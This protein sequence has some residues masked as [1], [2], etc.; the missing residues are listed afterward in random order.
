M[1]WGGTTLKPSA[2]PA[3]EVKAPV[4]FNSTGGAPA[5]APSGPSVAAQ[6]VKNARSNSRGRTPSVPRPVGTKQRTAVPPYNPLNSPYANQGQFNAA[7][8][9]TAK[10]EYQPELDSLNTEQGS[11]EGAHA[12][13]QANNVAL[14]EQYSK[15][16]QEAYGQAQ[17]SMA[18]IA[19]RQNSSTAAGQQTLQAALS[20]TGVAGLSGVSNPNAFMSEATGLG[21]EGSQTLAGEQS[22]ITGEMAKDMAG[23]PGAGLA[24]ATVTENAKEAGAL[25]KISGE[26][27]KVLSNIPNV[28]SKVRGELSKEE[29]ERQ[30]NNLQQQIAS[31]KL[32]LE[33]TTQQQSVGIEKEKIASSNTQHHEDAIQKNQELAVSSGFEAEKLKLER[34]KINASI[35]NAKTAEQKAAAELSGKR[36]DHGLELMA[37][38]LKENPKTEY[39]PGSLPAGTAPEP[40]KVEYR[41][42]AQHLYDMLTKQGNLT[43]PEAFR[44]MQSSGNGY[45]EQFARTHEHI[46][47]EANKVHQVA[48][49]IK[50]HPL[51]P[52]QQGK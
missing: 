4:T 13:R 51:K 42:D 30:A 29:Q 11:E 36:F 39:R 49:K 24:E 3:K 47:N 5:K 14:Y 10:G 52:L 1:A 2:P 7:V 44:L 25:S 32:G 17:G 22:A 38:Y 23:V 40:G 16:A 9:S 33:K 6:M 27:Q 19:A 34:E 28:Q 31:Q 15:Q 41:R 18:Q 50:A 12:Q 21:N 26:R 48:G 35:K 37:G 43:A 8:S 45:I 20:N 46:Y